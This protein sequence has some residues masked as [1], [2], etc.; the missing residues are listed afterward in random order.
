MNKKYLT[1]IACVAMIAPL[2]SCLKGESDDYEAWREQNDAYIASIDTKE[3]ELVV[4]D[5][6]PRN[7]VYIKWHNDR[8][9]TADNL[10]AMSNSTVE[11][12]YEVED[13]EGTMID[14]SYSATTGDSLY[15]KQ[16]NNTVVGFWIALTTMHVGDSATLIIPY[17]SGYGAGMNNNVRP[18]TN[19]IYR[20]KIK[21]IRAYEKPNT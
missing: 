5:W 8:A 12:K 15:V 14:N 10:V 13:I 7:S 18:Y 11:L 17:A 6:A 3:Y 4:P 21:G 1:A 20:V 2:T 19:L 16:P 9:L